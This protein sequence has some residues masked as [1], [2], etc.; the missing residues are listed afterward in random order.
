MKSWME[1]IRFVN[2]WRLLNIGFLVYFWIS[3]DLAANEFILLLLLIL[4]LLTSLRWRFNLPAWSVALDAFVCFLYFPYNAVSY[5]GLALPIFELAQRGKW[6]LSL[7]FFLGLFLVPFPSAWLFWYFVLALFVGLFS[8]AYSLNQQKYMEEADEQRRAR[9]EL[10]RIKIDLLAAQQSV[11]QQAELMERYRIARQLHDHLGHDLTGAA[12]ALQAYEYVEE[13]EEARNLLQ[14]V[15]RRLERSTRNLRETVYN[16]TP[17][18]PI[19]VENLE[20]VALNF[21]QVRI[22]FRKSGDLLRVAAYHWGLLEACLKEA[23]TNIARHSDATKVEVKVQAA[24][25]IIR[26]H[27]QDNG[28]VRQSRLPGSGLRSLKMRARSLGGS[29]SVSGDNGFLLVCVLPLRE[30]A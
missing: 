16:E 5:Y 20:Y 6:P 8:Y 1:P 24:G 30:E 11:A 28:T 23:L 13:A 26:L 10:E 3:G 27:V 19:G 7:L 21:Q 18:T 4:I 17:I 29:L 15:K 14:E 22:S 2:G 25:S 9:Y 12:L